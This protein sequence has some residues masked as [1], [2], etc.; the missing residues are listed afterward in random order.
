[1]DT[2]ALLLELYGRIPPLAA[3]AVRGLDTEQLCR[4]PAPGTNPIGWLVWH[5]GRIQDDHLAGVMDTGQLWVE[6]DWAA[7]F[8]LEPDPDNDGFGHTPADVASVR[9][10][11]PDVL[12]AYLKAVAHRTDDWLRSLQEEDFNRVVDRRWNPPVTLGVRL[13]SVADD[14]LQHC[15]QAAYVRGLLGF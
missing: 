12:T 7:G 4:L 8:G 10:S 9:P 2:S 14:G 15:G 5:M 1:M 6:G 13:V 3:A 11:G